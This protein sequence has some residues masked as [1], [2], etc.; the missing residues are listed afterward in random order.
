[1]IVDV[2]TG[3]YIEKPTE[4]AVKFFTEKVEFL[5][6]NL[7]KLQQTITSRQ[8]FLKATFD[9]IQTKASMVSASQS[10]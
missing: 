5:K 2:G 6:Q 9:A 10:K 1:M 3:Y 7:E 8:T 4:D